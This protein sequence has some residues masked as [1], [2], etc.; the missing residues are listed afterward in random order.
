M[1]DPDIAPE[2][3][4]GALNGLRRINAVTQTARLIWPDIKT[5]GRRNPDRP[6][7]VLDVGCGGGD[8]LITLFKKA[9]SAGID[10]SLYGCDISP[11]ALQHAA[12]RVKR[13][14]A[15]A[16]EI[17]AHDVLND[18]L[19]E[20]FDVILCTLFLH[21]LPDDKAIAFLA[22]A[23]QKAKDRIVVQDLVRSPAGYAFAKVGVNFLLCNK[24]CRADGPRSVEGAF[25]PN[26]ARDLAR[27][28][29]LKGANVRARFPFRY[30]LRWVR[31]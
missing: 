28:A 16:V 23:A 14:G 4:I 11:V 1:D 17:F 2:L 26:E 29:G 3:F 7:R 18:Q 21:H 10:I 5:A 24:I 20:G 8:V 9:A 6:L 19:P 15:E 25:T 31:P 27:R 30:V 13:F 22:D 12:T